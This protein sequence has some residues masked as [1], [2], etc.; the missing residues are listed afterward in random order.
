MEGGASNEVAESSKKIG[1]GKIEIKR[2]ENTT[3]RQVT[4]CKRRN[5]LLK[6][7]YELSVLCDAEVALVIFSTRGRLYE[8]ANNSVRGTIERYKKA[9]S[10]AVNPPTIT[11]ANTQYYQQ[12]ASKL[13]RQIRDIQ[14][15]NRHIL[16]ESLGSLN[17]KELKNLESRLEK[18]ISRV[19]SKKHEMLVAEIEYMQKREIELQNDNMYLRSKIT[20]RTG[21]QQQE[22]SVIHQGTVYESGV[23]SS[24]QSGQYN[25]NYIA[26]NLLEPNQNSSNQDQPPLQLV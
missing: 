19:R 12:E 13:R 2:I 4:F 26:V 17:F 24:H 21:L 1:R 25:R 9:C 14:N 18:G 7:A 6:K 22:S 23:T 5:G 8:Y 3:N 10:D 20:E 16:G 11:E 15:L